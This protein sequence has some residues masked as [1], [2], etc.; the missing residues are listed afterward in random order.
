MGPPTP[1]TNPRAVSARGRAWELASIS[2]TAR[3]PGKA[4]RAMGCSWGW[5]PLKLGS[6]H[7]QPPSS[8]RTRVAHPNPPACTRGPR[9]PRDVGQ[10]VPSC[11]GCRVLS[12]VLSWGSAGGQEGLA[13]PPRTGHVSLQLL[14]GKGCV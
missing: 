14:P 4:G 11:L 9:Q 10:R 3:H 12:R 2:G 8:G 13:T 6:P 7:T 1:P 5:V